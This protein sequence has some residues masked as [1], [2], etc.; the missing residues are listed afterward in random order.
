MKKFLLLPVLAFL[1]LNQSFAQCCNPF[2]NPSFEGTVKTDSTPPP[3]WTGCRPGYEGTF[4]LS[5]V[6]VFPAYGGSTYAAILFTE[7]GGAITQGAISQQLNCSLSN[8]DTLTIALVDLPFAS[9]QNP[10]NAVCEIYGGNNSCDT[11]QLLWMGAIANTAT[12]VNPAWAQ[13]TFVVHPT[14]SYPYITIVTTT[15]TP[16]QAQHNFYVGIDSLTV[17]C[18]TP[19]TDID[20]RTTTKISLYPNPTTGTFIVNTGNNDQYTL[21]LFDQTGRELITKEL[22]GSGTIDVSQL[23][24]GAYLTKIIQ[25]D[26]SYSQKLIIQ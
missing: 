3:H 15:Q 8:G 6:D 9:N 22:A 23:A 4:P 13:N 1:C 20:E 18:N 21:K 11:S 16:S 19:A 2:Q 10:D 7:S 14:G 25:G 5:S 26:K 24:K 17:K 12:G